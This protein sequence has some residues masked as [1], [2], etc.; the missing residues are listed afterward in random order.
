M[1]PKRGKLALWGFVAI[2]AAWLFA[3]QARGAEESPAG[4]A[5][6]TLVINLTSGK[7][8]LHA[9]VMGFHLAEHGLA[10]RREVVLFFNVKAPPLA[11]K[12]L[13]ESV[14]FEDLPPVRVMINGLIEKGAKILVCPMCAEITGVSA[15][16]LAPG[17]T[18][19]EDRRQLF[20]HL[21]ADA[22]VFTY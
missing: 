16:E 17:V 4:E 7:E 10:D 3:T 5:K 12:T 18:M 1:Q 19:I 6:P 15:D 8:D 20:D 21:H 13:D 2:G 14:R 9:V 22:V 11:R